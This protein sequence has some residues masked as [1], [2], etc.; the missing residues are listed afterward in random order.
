[1]Y[2]VLIVEDEAVIARGLQYAFDWSSTDCV[3]T[4][5]AHNGIEGFNLIKQHKPQIVL[6]DI[7][8]PILNG[9]DMIAQAKDAGCLFAA[10]I[11]TGYEEFPLAQKAIGLG[12]VEYL[13]KPVDHKAL[14]LAVNKSKETLT[15][16]RLLQQVKERGPLESSLLPNKSSNS[17]L[18]EQIITYVDTY[19]SKQISI[20]GIADHLNVSYSTVTKCFK[21]ET[22]MT[23]NEY[24]NR[25]RISKSIEMMR[26]KKETIY[27][28]AELVGFTDYKYFIKVFSKYVQVT[29]NQFMKNLPITD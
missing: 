2:S 17:R 1:M 5:V 24:I 15:Q 27:M 20:Q 10:I 3:I 4:A 7:S 28:I 9:L 12:V 29:P 11:I 6:A 16:I 25:V 14:S 21:E 26:T 23:L 19:F 8:M 18:G 13:L 22:N